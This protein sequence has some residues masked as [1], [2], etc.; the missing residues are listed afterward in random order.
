MPEKVSP[1]ARLLK[2][3]GRLEHVPAGRWL[4]GRV[5][6]HGIPYT[7]TIRPEVLV[8]EPGH[9]RVRLRDRR[10]VRNHLD[11]VHA[12]AVTNVGELTTGLAVTAALPEA[13][14]SIL[15]ALHVEFLKKARG[16]LVAECRCTVPRVEGIVNYQASSEV[17]DGAGDVVA[18]VTATWRLENR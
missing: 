7:G 14:R 12:I 4:F 10:R 16:P 6:A 11:S 1:P 5:L 15:T 17:T 9:A 2:W 13:V 8:V 3:W 18:R